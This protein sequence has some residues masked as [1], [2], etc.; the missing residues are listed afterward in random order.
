V[1]RETHRDGALAVT[2]PIFYGTVSGGGKI[3]YDYPSRYGSWLGKLAGKRVE[4]IVRR[5]RVQRSTQANRYYWGVV[6]PL[7]AE[8]WGYEKQ[9]MHEVL[10]MH[11]LRIEDCPV[12]GAPRRKRTPD[13][14][15]AE[16]AAYTDSCIRL[17]AE[18]GIVVPSPNEVEVSP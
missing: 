6:V 14:D 15:T 10:A 17:A 9:E 5:E 2:P 8:E 13:T 18:H 3:V 4:V 11:F 1:D 7:L 12:T 16:F